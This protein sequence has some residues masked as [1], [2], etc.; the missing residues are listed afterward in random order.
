MPCAT[1][2]IGELVEAFAREEVKTG[3]RPA[4]VYLPKEIYEM[5]VFEMAQATRTFHS[6]DF[7]TKLEGVLVREHRHRDIVFGGEPACL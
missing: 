6:E 1:K 7:E 2:A 5:V 4:C 3:T